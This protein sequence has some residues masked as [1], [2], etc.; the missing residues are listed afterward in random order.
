M[1]LPPRRQL[2][3]T[4]GAIFGF[5]GPPESS[6]HERMSQA[7]RHRGRVGEWTDSTPTGTLAYRA[8]A[9]EPLRREFVCG[10]YAQGDRTVAM[11]GR[12]YGDEQ[13]RSLRALLAGYEQQGTDVLEQLRGTFVL[14]IRD[15]STIHLARDG[16]GARTISYACYQDRFF[17]SVEPKAIVAVPRFPRRLR[18]ASIAQYLTFSF[19]PGER[20]MIE[21]VFELPAGHCVTFEPGKPLRLTRWFVPESVAM[22]NGDADGNC[23]PARWV[24]EFRALLGRAVAERLPQSEPPTV[25]LSGGL[26]SSVVTAEVVR[27]SSRPVRT[28][29]PKRTGG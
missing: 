2:K 5:S 12:L 4:M 7:L 19:V 14:A 10:L 1:R 21:D 11:A 20:T 13:P 26:D 23:D 3:A 24:H 16:A 18:N 8:A 22:R 25:F 29:A 6:W 27:Q 17:F 28:F 9:A 15:G